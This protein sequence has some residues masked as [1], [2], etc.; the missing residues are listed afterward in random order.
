MLD[1]IIDWAIHLLDALHRFIKAVEYVLVDLAS[2]FTP[3][4]A[5]VIPAY[6]VYVSMVGILSFPPWVASVGA[7]VTE[8]LG[9]ATVYTTLEFWQWNDEKRKSD[10]NAPFWVALVVG[11]FYVALVMT[12]NVMLDPSPWNRQGW[13]LRAAKAM[14]S[15]MSV[16]GGIT[17]ALRSQHR[18][19]LREITETKA[20]A[21]ELRAQRQGQIERP[22][23]PAAR[24]V[25]AQARI[26]D[27]LAIY[28]E[29]LGHPAEV[30]RLLEMS[31]GTVKSAMSRLRGNGKDK[32]DKEKSNESLLP[33]KN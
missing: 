29:H 7:L 18:R 28:P 31:E 3:W 30:A 33:S 11:V 9:L 17:I 21:R 27:H 15:L 25:G 23:A 20:E 1:R 26:A 10:S 16:V 22:K 13:L 14:L 6:M 32:N 24:T 5:P 12:L 8:F 19:R 2:A 4:L